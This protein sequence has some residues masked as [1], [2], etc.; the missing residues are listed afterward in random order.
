MLVGKIIGK[1]S[2]ES[3]NFEVT[4]IIRKMDFVATR[5]P[6]RHWV[7]GRIDD[8]IQQETQTI[9]TVSVIGYADKDGVKM[10]RIPFKPNSYVYKADDASIKK[11]LGLKND[12]LYVGIL[13]GSEKLKVY[14]DP[15]LL[16]TKHLAILAK[17]GFGKSYL[18]GVLLEEF[19]E[20]E[21]PAVVI[22]P[23]GEYLTLRNPNKK[24]EEIKYMPIFDIEPKGYSKNIEIYCLD[25]N[26]TEGARRLKLRGK[27]THQEILDMLP[28][29]LSPT[30]LSIIY[31]AVTESEKQE[32][33]LDELK[34]EVMKNKSPSKWTVIPVL[35][36]IKSTGLFDVFGYITPQDLVKKGKISIINLKGIEPDIQQLVVYKLAKDLF[37]ARKMNKIPPFIFIIEEAHNFAPERSFGEAISSRVIRTIAS[38]GRKFGMGLCVI[39]QRPARIDKNV[40]S[41]CTTQIFLRITNPNDLKSI[42]DS[43]EGITKGLESQ[44]KILP[45]GTA[46]V[47]GLIEQ[48]LLVNVRIKKTEHGGAPASLSEK[49]KEQESGNI[50]YFYPK[51]FEEDVKKIASKDIERIKLIYYPLYYLKCKFKTTEGDKI[52]NIFV[53]GMTGELVYLNNNL[54]ERTGGFTKLLELDT[55]QKAVAI[56]LTSYGSTD[57]NTISKRLKIKEEELMDILSFLKKKNI[58][59]MDGMLFKSNLKV[60]FE[61]ILEKQIQEAPLSYKYT[62]EVIEPKVK[63]E[64]IPKILDIFNPDAV[65][66]KTAFYPFW[67][68]VLSDGTVEVVDGLT[69]EKDE[70][71]KSTGFID[72]ISLHS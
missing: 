11:V 52:D 49:F 37:F 48:P 65:D 59:L 72:N 36:L 28:F 6:E 41:Q 13:D 12:G 62:G 70:Y 7:L 45:I 18:A 27:L 23:H 3:Y 4:G 16:M 71:L 50:L 20:N 39:T 21:I 68:L 15:K 54:L 26:L 34:R 10:P 33:T 38:E 29:K 46:C 67:I 61:E 25:K 17:S 64:I 43:V 56:F 53:D 31:T 42:S 69:G 24:Q 63:K 9:A 22:D 60:N 57:F 66:K 35:D 40:L 30:Q 14:L 32:Y 2:P 44:I 8:I 58:V 1:T 51:F 19:I 55:K 5:D 47:V